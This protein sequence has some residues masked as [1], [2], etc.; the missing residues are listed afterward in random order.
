MADDDDM[1]K[2][3]TGV[4]MARSMETV[5]IFVFLSVGN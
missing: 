3:K 2:T 5:A 1:E 4:D